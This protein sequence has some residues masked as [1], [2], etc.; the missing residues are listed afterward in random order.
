MVVAKG[1]LVSVEYTLRLDNQ[2]IY[3]TNVGENPL[4]YTHGQEEI[5]SGLERGLEGMAI[6][7]NKTV[8]VMP[9]E[10]YGDMHPEGLFEVSRE[11][12]PAAALYIGTKLEAQAPDGTPVYPYVAEI[13]DDSVVLNLNHPLAGQRLH[14]DVTILDIKK[15]SGECNN[16]ESKVRMG[17]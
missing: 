5:I 14:F 6:G 2:E 4:T 13:K 1:M 17:T 7:Q 16:T 11:R 15:L 10:G 3:E 8:I 12:I 9:S